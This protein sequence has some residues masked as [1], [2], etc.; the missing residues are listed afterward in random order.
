MK[1]SLGT[2]INLK[3]R[4]GTSQ[5]LSYG[6]VSKQ[7]KTCEQKNNEYAMIALSEMNSK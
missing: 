2:T 7:Y 5:R 6:Q 1:T 4:W 3:H